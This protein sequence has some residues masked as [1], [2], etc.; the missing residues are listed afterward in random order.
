MVL[1]NSDVMR[2]MG[3]NPGDSLTV[4]FHY[5]H[6]PGVALPTTNITRSLTSI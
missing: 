5:K 3:T 6:Q 4:V 1:W 2:M